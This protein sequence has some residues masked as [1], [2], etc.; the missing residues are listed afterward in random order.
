MSMSEKD[1]IMSQL[2]KCWNLPA[3]AKDADKLAVL[4]DAEYNGTA[5]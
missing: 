4:I 2:A 3:G 1:A 5:R